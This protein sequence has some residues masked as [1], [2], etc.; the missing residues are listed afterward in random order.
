[1]ANCDKCTKADDCSKCKWKSKDAKTGDYVTY[2][3]KTVDC[4]TELPKRCVGDKVAVKGACVA[5]TAK[6][7]NCVIYGFSDDKVAT[8]EF[9]E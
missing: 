1:M 4:D 9:A 7:T 8:L 6:E 5:V 2:K 3:K